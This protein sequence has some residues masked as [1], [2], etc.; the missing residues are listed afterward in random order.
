MSV[1]K[2]Q[3]WLD[4][5][6]PH[7][8]RSFEPVHRNVLEMFRAAVA[9]AP[10]HPLMHYFSN[11]ISAA[12][13]DRL[14]DALGVGLIDLGIERGDRIAIDLQNVPQFVL[15]A[16]AA[17]K[18]GGIVVPIN[19]MLRQHELEY[20]LGDSGARVV[21]TLES[22][23]QEVV[24]DVTPT[25]KVEHVITTSELD[26]LDGEVPEL[27]ASSARIECEGSQD[28][29][30]LMRAHEGKTPPAI[31]LAPQDIA[32]LPY[33]SGTTGPPKGAMNTHANVVYNA[34]VSRG[35]FN[36]QD[37]DVILALAPLFHIT[38]FIAHLALCMTGPFPLVLTYR[39]DP[40]T[41]AGLIE[42]HRVTYTIGAI[43]A[44]IAMIN[45]PSVEA[46]ELR[47]LRQV[48][49]GG[50]PIAPSTVVEF[51]ERFGL[52]I[53]SGYGLTETSAPTHLTPTGLDTPVDAGSA[54]LAIGIPINQC[55]ARVVDENG[56]EVA[57]G[58]PG[59][60][61][62]KGPMVVPGYWQKPAE[63]ADTFKNG[64][65]YTGD[66][67]FMDERGWFYVVDRKKDMIIASGYKVWPREVEDVVY[68]HGA[69]LEAAV[70]GVP[71]D[72]RG[73]TVKLFVSLKPGAE[74]TAEEII[75]YC[76]DRLAAYKRPRYVEILEELP[77]TT[78]GKILRRELRG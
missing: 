14:S 23:Y 11:S 77:K 15:T 70:V 8:D 69:V 9:R 68:S 1:Y 7:V 21:I 72:Y 24:K 62:I 47:S 48:Y 5:Y 49:S 78:T 52:T 67:G 30:E 34:V 13:A 36:L 43:T 16:L 10:G 65:V 44:Y 73:E 33:T 76:R 74:L 18:A 59:E 26:F 54:A 40:K 37:D 2:K 4:L 17:W 50:A 75:D 60:I 55:M 45:T 35:W 71:D 64:E 12:E 63:T 66:V 61:L 42:R 27:L 57:P 41:T 29:V 39:F 3:P 25:T 51:K 31:E 58:E 56:R 22:L 46:N 53:R 32:L 20:L 28:L 6:D 19:P 38:G